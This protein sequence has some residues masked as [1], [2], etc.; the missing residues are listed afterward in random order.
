MKALLKVDPDWKYN[1]Q[2]LYAEHPQ[3]GTRIELKGAD[4]ED[5]LRGVGLKSAGLDECAMMK[6]NVWPE[7]IRP[8]LADSGGRATF[9]STPKGRN[10]FFDLYMKGIT[11]EPNWS[12]WKYPTSI[13]KYIAPDEVEQARKDMPERLFKQEFLAEFLDDETGVF[14]RVRQCVTGEL[15]APVTG[16]FYVIGVDLAKT[17]DFTV[18][19]VIDTVTRQVVAFER[20]QD[21]SWKEQKLI[22]QKL[23]KRYNNALVIIDSHGVGDP[24]Y[25]DLQNAYVSIEGFKFTNISKNQLIDQLAISIEQRLITFPPIEVLLQELMQFEYVIS[26]GGRIKYSAPEGKHDDCVISLALANWGIRSYLYTAQAAV[27]QSPQDP[28]DRQGYGTPVAYEFEEAE[29]VGGY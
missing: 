27:R 19:T 1:E 24:I 26:D 16:R 28:V 13:N 8:M 11:G 6:A 17:V 22:I 7:I 21:V 25:E 20:F 2:E 9:I 12:S 23:A 10:W 14:K 18:L 5:S 3:I 4:N 29:S 15:E